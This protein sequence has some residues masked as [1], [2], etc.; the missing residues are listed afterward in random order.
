MRM[1]YLEI[2][3]V[4]RIIE[5]RENFYAYLSDLCYTSLI[6]LSKEFRNEQ[7]LLEI[8]ILSQKEITN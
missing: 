3:K 8:G 7:I 6:A 5:Y 2:G 4:D 1:L